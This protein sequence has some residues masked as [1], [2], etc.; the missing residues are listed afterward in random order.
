MNKETIMSLDNFSDELDTTMEM[1]ASTDVSY[2]FNKLHEETGEVAEVGSAIMGSENKTRK[3]TKKCGSVD[4]ALLE[5]L[6]DTTVVTMILALKRGFTIEQVLT[7]ATRKMKI[8][9]DK[10]RK[11]ACQKS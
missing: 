8:K 11:A 4:L 2:F 3:L 7:E 5:E 10:R 9:N 6:A 1:V